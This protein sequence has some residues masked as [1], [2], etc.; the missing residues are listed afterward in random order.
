MTQTREQLMAPFAALV[1]RAK[2]DGW[3]RPDFEFADITMT[4][5]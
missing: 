1:K 4:T 5:R 3:L 2:A